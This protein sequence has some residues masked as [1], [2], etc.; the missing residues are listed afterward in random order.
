MRI[1]HLTIRNFRSIQTLAVDLPQVCALVGPNNA[2]KS[3]LLDAIRRVLGGAWLRVSD[4]GPDDIYLRDP[5][6]D[7]DIVCTLDPPLQYAKFKAAPPTEIHGFSFQYTRYK[8]GE[9]TSDW[10]E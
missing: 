5:E 10:R 1:K 7:I 4:F 8:V 6:R 9:N 3:N 2:G